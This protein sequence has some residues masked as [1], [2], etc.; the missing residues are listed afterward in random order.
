MSRLF[1]GHLTPFGCFCGQFFAGVRHAEVQIGRFFV[2]D[3]V[4]HVTGVLPRLAV[5]A[6]HCWAQQKEAHVLFMA[7]S[8]VNDYGLVGTV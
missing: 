8:F 3:A 1:G 6:L 4:D 5:D 7:V 2:H